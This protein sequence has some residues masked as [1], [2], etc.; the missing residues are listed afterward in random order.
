MFQSDCSLFNFYATFCWIN[1]L[2]ILQG[3]FKY[4]ESKFWLTYLHI[5]LLIT[6]VFWCVRT[7]TH[8][9]L[10][11]CFSYLPLFT[12][13]IKILVNSDK[14]SGYSNRCLN[15]LCY[16]NLIKVIKILKLS[17]FFGIIFY[18]IYFK[19]ENL[20]TFLSTNG[21]TAYCLHILLSWFQK[22]FVVVCKSNFASK[23]Y[24]Q[25]PNWLLDSAQQ[26]TNETRQQRK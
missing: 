25:K 15:F 22:S 2:Y 9:A 12:R 18:F 23:H 17:L 3:D 26:N 24:G 10:C 14:T 11:P 20:V 5:Y 7:K 6:Y 8:I 16:E 13:K 4:L 19:N 1:Y 21:Y